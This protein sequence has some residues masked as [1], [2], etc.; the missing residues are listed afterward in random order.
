MDVYE[1]CIDEVTDILSGCVGVKSI[2]L[3]NNELKDRLLEIEETVEEKIAYGMCRTLNRGLREAF[4][5]DVTAALL[6]NSSIYKYPHHPSMVMIYDDV[7][8]GEQVKDEEK[9]EELRKDRKN[10]FLWDEFVIYTP[11]LPREK[12][13]KQRLRM[14]YKPMD[15]EQLDPVQCVSDQVFGTPSTEGDSVLKEAMGW[16]ETVPEIGTCVIG[17]NLIQS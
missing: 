9:R 12:E 7:V 10:F 16:G 17:F 1:P 3:I 11:L 13:A 14:V 15:V 8:V 4:K 6:I 5:R 2:E